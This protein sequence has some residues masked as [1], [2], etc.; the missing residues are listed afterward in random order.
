MQF[1]ATWVAEPPPAEHPDIWVI[2]HD[3]ESADVV[4]DDS[5]PY[6]PRVCYADGS[7]KL[8][9]GAPYGLPETEKL[10][11]S[12]YLTLTEPWQRFWYALLKYY[13]A[14]TMTEAA[15][16]KAWANLT[17]DDRAFTNQRGSTTL[18]DYINNTNAD[19]PPMRKEGVTTCGNVVKAAGEAVVKGG[20]LCL[21]VA[22]IDYNLP[23]PVVADVVDKRYLIHFATIC[24]PELVGPVREGAPNGEFQV[25][26]FPQLGGLDVPVPMIAK[27]GVNW[28]DVIRLRRIGEGEQYPPNPYV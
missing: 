27:G 2:K 16:K 20:K 3:F 13:S 28:I 24:R 5:G 21:P 15:L 25:N 8:R 11:V 10:I 26:P 23:P 19:K 12:D 6:M 22:C 1:S 4:Y 17:A 7:P 14:G 9:A 18:R